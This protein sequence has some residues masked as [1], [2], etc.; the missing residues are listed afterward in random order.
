MYLFIMSSLTMAG[1][2]ITPRM[3]VLWLSRY[4]TVT[5]GI[6]KNYRDFISFIRFYEFDIFFY[7]RIQGDVL[8]LGK[9][10]KKQN[11]CLA[12]CQPQQAFLNVPK[13]TTQILG[14]VPWYFVFSQKPQ[15]HNFHHAFGKFTHFLT[16]FESA[17]RF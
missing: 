15:R 14:G 1:T 4:S 2:N 7:V 9:K 12:M 11:V 8:T 6:Y 17:L 5:H 16:H 13:P 3:L 10:N